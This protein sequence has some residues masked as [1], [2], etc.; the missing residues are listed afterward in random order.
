MRRIRPFALLLIPFLVL[1]GLGLSPSLDTVVPGWVDAFGGRQSVR[2]LHFVAAM[3]VVAFAAVHVFEVV[4]TG[5]WNNLR[6]MITG[7]YRTPRGEPR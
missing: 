7:R 4:V 1:M 2:T 3:L 5:F 6:S